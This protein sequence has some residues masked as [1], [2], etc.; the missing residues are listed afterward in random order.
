MIWKSVSKVGFGYAWKKSGPNSY[1]F[2]AV[3]NYL[4]I[5]NVYLSSKNRIQYFVGNVT[6][7]K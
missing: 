2:W 4:P 5:P 7:P 6:Q 3:A 1:E